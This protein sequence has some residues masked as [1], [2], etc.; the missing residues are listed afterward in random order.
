VD[1]IIKDILTRLLVYNWAFGVIVVALAV[2]G[3]TVA[4]RH[5]VELLGHLETLRLKLKK[6]RLSDA[7]LKKKIGEVCAELGQLLAT[8][9]A[10]DPVWN[11]HSQVDMAS[12]ADRWS[13]NTR[14]MIHEYEVRILP[15]IIFYREELLKRKYQDVEL[16]RSYEHPTNPIGIGIVA[17]RLGALGE[18]LKDA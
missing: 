7:E 12:Y 14:A 6:A 3:A 15:R 4:V 17:S 5:F 10:N 11:T 2:V 16:D 9:S 1:D 18:K 13:R 8:H